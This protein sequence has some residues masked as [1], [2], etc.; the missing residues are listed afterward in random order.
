MPK[1]LRT[2]EAGFENA[3]SAFL[4][5]KRETSADI[6]A[7]VAQILADVKARGDAALIEF[8]RKFDH[9]DL[10]KVGLRVTRRRCLPR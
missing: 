5:E 7:A 6:E 8:S 10:E 2:A 9:V 1:R 4:A 3:F